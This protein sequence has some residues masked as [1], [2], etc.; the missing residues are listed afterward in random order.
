MVV[1]V[2]RVAVGGMQQVCQLYGAN[3][4]PPQSLALPAHHHG[5]DMGYASLKAFYT[6]VVHIDRTKDTLFVYIQCL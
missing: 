2:C 5:P 3:Q 1:G 4:R 6:A